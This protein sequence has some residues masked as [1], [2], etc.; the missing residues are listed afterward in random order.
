MTRTIQSLGIGA[1]LVYGAFIV[2]LYVA[3]PRTIAELKTSAAVQTN[4]YEVD[5]TQFDLGVKAFREGDFRIAIDRFV[6]ADPAAEDPKTLFLIAS[7]HYALGAGSIYDDDTEFQAALAAVDR[8]LEIAPNNTYTL[9]D[10]T[11]TVAYPSAEK[12]RERLRDGLQVTPGDFN[13]FAAF[14]GV[15]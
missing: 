9:D 12:L 6:R 1:T 15:T 2:W 10:A 14:G 13:P 8:C 4:V 5:R 11:I 3:Q 7:A